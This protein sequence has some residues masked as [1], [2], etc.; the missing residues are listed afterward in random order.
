MKK[1]MKSFA[2]RCIA[3]TVE[4]KTPEAM[5]LM[6][7]GLEYYS[8]NVINALSPYAKMDAGM[9]VFVLRHIADEVEKGNPGAKE[10]YDGLKGC[11]RPTSLVEVEKVKKATEE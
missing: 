1:R 11:V 5:K 3:L 8:N 2:D 7:R 9:V 4:G 6:E 10:L